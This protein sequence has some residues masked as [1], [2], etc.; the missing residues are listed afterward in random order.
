[1][2]R[3]YTQEQLDKTYEKLPQELQEALFSMET[4]ESIGQVCDSYGIQDERR[5]QVSDFAGHV[6]MGLL[7]PQEFAD[8][9]EKEV[10]LSKVLAQAIARDLNRFV[11]YPVRP[12]LEQLHR[13]EIE[14]SARVVTPQPAEEG[15]APTEKPRQAGPDTYREPI[16]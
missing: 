14:V 2:P 8:V 10:K 3:Q 6:L 7:L 15:E 5:G 1:M 9:L 11:F 12:A 13:M 4:A 16:E